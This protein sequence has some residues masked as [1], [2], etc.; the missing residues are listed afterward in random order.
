[1]SAA[2]YIM[3]IAGTFQSESTVLCCPYFSHTGSGICWSWLAMVLWQL[4][5]HMAVVSCT[6]LCFTGRYTISLQCILFFISCKSTIGTSWLVA[7]WLWSQVGIH[8]HKFE[9]F[10]P[11]YFY[12]VDEGKIPTYLLAQVK[13]F[14]YHSGCIQLLVELPTLP[15]P[16]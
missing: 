4:M 15:T 16:C 10:S 9:Q 13:I 6:S 11:R 2:H 12:R 7:A 14:L 8:E 1:M 3:L 5:E